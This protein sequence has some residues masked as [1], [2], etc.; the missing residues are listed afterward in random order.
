ME[1][2]E[3]SPTPGI[4]PFRGR[5]PGLDGLSGKIQVQIAS[6]PVALVT[7][8]GMDVEVAPGGG[9]ADAVMDVHDIDALIHFLRGELNPI[10]AFLQDRFRAEGNLVFALNVI[11]GLQVG[12]SFKGEQL[13][14]ET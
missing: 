2:T 14:K 3:S 11:L 6:R 10:V 9:E 5:A 13:K 4:L 12:S 1:T 8:N 7:V